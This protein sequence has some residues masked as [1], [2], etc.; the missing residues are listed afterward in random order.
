M[1][2][3]TAAISGYVWNEHLRTSRWCVL[4][5]VAVWLIAMI[6]A[7][8]T[9]QRG[10]STIVYR[11]RNAFALCFT[12]HFVAVLVCLVLWW[13]EFSFNFVGYGYFLIP[14]GLMAI[15]DLWLA[16]KLFFTLGHYRSFH[17]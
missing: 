1:K 12:L 16:I 15:L 3:L 17:S 14:F 10:G 11:C 8:R 5:Y 2:Q 7:Q 9:K 4:G 13:R 6:I